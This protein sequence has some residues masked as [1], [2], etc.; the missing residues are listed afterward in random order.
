MAGDQW[1]LPGPAGENQM[2]ESIP[3][4]DIDLWSDDLLADPYPAYRELRAIGPVVRLPR[5]D[6][7]ALT[8]YV[9][10]RA[11]LPDW[12]TFRSGRGVGV[13]PETNARSASNGI[14][15]TDPPDHQRLRRTLAGQLGSHRLAAH[16]PFLTETAEAMV[17]DVV[18]RTR[19]DAVAE[20]AGPYSVKVVADL[21]GLPE[22]ERSLLLD[23]AARAFD[24]MGPDCPR[25]SAGQSG[26]RE[27]FDYSRSVVDERRLASG[28]WGDEIRTAS[29]RGDISRSDGVGLIMAYA[30]AGMDTTV[31]AIA[32]AIGLF[33]ANSDQWDLLRREPSLMMPAV[34]EVLR[35]EPVVQRF[36][37]YVEA[38]TVVDRHHIPAGSRLL[39]LF[40]SANR[41]PDHYADPDRFDVTRN[42]HDHL[43]FGRGIHRCVGAPLAQ[44]EL[45]AVLT[46]LTARVR[47]FSVVESEPLI[48]HALHGHR[49]LLVDVEPA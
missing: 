6:L 26:L 22:D 35:I 10:I 15:T 9:D 3:I 33:A 18:G 39:V 48:N 8:R 34:H 20:L 23:R 28:R 21:V 13:D 7:L 5:H 32:S 16:L 11:V 42:P 41:D 43:S 29:D 2:T 4:S 45:S 40:G 24:T 1:D 31:N 27:L 38:D 12:E 30:W 19:F 25:T 14:L 49:R 46:A 37:R 44:H 47:R 36:T 17:A